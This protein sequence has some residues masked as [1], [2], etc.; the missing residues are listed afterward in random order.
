MSGKVL[1]FLAVDEKGR[2]TIPKVMR[3][4]LGIRTGTHLRVDV[5]ADGV[6]ELVPSELV[7]HDQLWFHTPSVQAGIAEAEEDFRAGRSVRTEGPEDTQRFLD[8]L[9]EDAKGRRKRRG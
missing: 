5:S 1:G 9:K 6:V 2:T 4:A 8:S 7:P 3:Q